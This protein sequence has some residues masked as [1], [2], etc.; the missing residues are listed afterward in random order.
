MSTLHYGQVQRSAMNWPIYAALEL[1]LFREEGVNFAMEVFA[2]PPRAV[3][4]LAGGSLQVL[5]A[6]PDPVLRVVDRGAPL[7]LIAAVLS[8][9][10][11][12]L[13]AAGNVRSVSDLKGKRLAV[14][15]ADSAESLLLRRFLQ[16]RGLDP[17]EFDWVPAGPPPERCRRLQE[18]KVEATLVSQPFD[19]VLLNGGCRVLFD[20]RQS[21]PH[22]PFAVAVVSQEWAGQHEGE[23]VSFLRVL[24]RA[25]SW[26][27]DPGHR[28]RAA[29][30][31]ARATGAGEEV[32]LQ[33]YDYYFARRLRSTLEIDPKGIATILSLLDRTG[34]KP[35]DYL[36]RRYLAALASSGRAPE[37]P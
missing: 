20:S 3:E 24:Q 11:Y 19:F 25:V 30:V 7:R 17:A 22:Y 37:G 9:P 26:L 2:S 5:H 35:E 10:S 34:V 4:A 28:A 18:G 1:E 27:E 16:E 13:L 8:R 15:E 32:A 29:A 12:R 21:F 6:I 23:V 36:D 31:L 33:T 14:N